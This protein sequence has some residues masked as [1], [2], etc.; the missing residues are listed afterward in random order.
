M[1]GGAYDFGITPVEIGEVNAL[2]RCDVFD[3]GIL[4]GR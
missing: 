1:R 2:G 3:D 4:R